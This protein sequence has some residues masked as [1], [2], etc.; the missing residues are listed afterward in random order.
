MPKITKVEVISKPDKKPYKKLTLDD[1]REASMFDG[2]KGYAMV[3]SGVE[4]SDGDI[5]ARE[6]KGK[7]Y[8]NVKDGERR[9]YPSKGNSSTVSE[10]IERT[11][12]HKDNSFKTTATQRDSVI[13]VSSLI[14]AGAY[15]D[16]TK[17]FSKMAFELDKWRRHF[18]KNWDFTEDTYFPPTDRYEPTEEEISPDDV[19]GF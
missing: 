13:M 18:W 8:W 7:T 3:A 2:H 15:G 9:S 11:L 1:G 10:S 19:V 17:D 6:F 5:V 4:L 16:R 12:V 14:Q